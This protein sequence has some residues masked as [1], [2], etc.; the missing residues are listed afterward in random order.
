[1]PEN[2]LPYDGQCLLYPRFINSFELFH[3]FPA[4]MEDLAWQ[5]DVV[6]IY[7]KEITTARKTAWYGLY[8]FQYK[9]SGIERT[10]LP[11]TLELEALRRKC[12]YGTG[13]TYNSA[14]LNLYHSGA[15][16]MGWH[17]DDEDSIVPESAIAS[18][19]FGAERKFR[20]RH[21]E[22]REVVEMTLPNGSLLV[23]SGKTQQCWKHELPKM[24]KVKEPRINITFRLMK[25]EAISKIILANLD[26]SL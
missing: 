22:T 10:A 5:N 26:S 24:L 9:Y 25:H 23:M 4:L 6:K 17:S 11:F 21:N 19:S 16:G 20:F 15:E 12:E 3:Y 7:G 1:M 13:H 8:P 18:L 2:L 14:L